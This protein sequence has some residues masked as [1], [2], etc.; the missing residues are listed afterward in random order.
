MLINDAVFQH[1]SNLKF[2]IPDVEK[3]ALTEEEKFWLVR[4]QISR[5]YSIP[6]R[7]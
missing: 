3:G 4:M 2:T 5:F 6:T 1:F 7:L